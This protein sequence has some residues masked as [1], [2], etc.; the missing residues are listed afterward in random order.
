[1]GDLGDGLIGLPFLPG[2]LVSLFSPWSRPS[3]DRAICTLFCPDPLPERVLSRMDALAVWSG[4]SQ[5]I[6]ETQ[7]P[8]HPFSLAGLF[9]PWLHSSVPLH[10]AVPLGSHQPWVWKELLQWSHGYIWCFLRLYIL[11]CI[12]LFP[13]PKLCSPVSPPL[14]SVPPPPGDYS[15]FKAQLKRPFFQEPPQGEAPFTQPMCLRAGSPSFRRK[16]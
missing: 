14:H 9:L 5:P 7:H 16:A 10:S 15:F 3:L 4:Q 8:H 6:S 13:G 12:W 1:M 2:F 11:S